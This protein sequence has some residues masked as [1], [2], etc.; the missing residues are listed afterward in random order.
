[1]LLFLLCLFVFSLL[2]RV[3]LR[4]SVIPPFWKK[5]RNVTGNFVTL[6]QT[7]CDSFSIAIVSS[8]FWL[9]FEIGVAEKFTFCWDRKGNVRAD[10]D[11]IK[12][13]IYDLSE[14]FCAP[15]ARYKKW[16]RD[17]DTADVNWLLHND[18]RHSCED[19]QQLEKEIDKEIHNSSTFWTK[20]TS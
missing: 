3:G 15:Q 16:C 6:I 12:R 19:E 2:Q 7:E 5:D 18:T 17:Q 14:L 10:G 1:M 9:T 4:F 11:L 8:F 20:R 13:R